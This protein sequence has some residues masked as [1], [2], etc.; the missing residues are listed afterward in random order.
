[1]GF[2]MKPNKEGMES[3]VDTSCASEWNNK[4]ASIN[5]NLAR[6]RMGY[7]VTF[8]GYP[9]HWTSKVLTEIA[10]SSTEPECIPPL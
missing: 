10:L 2:I 8:A 4:T 7:I 9:M 3:W 5:P 1:M 6:S